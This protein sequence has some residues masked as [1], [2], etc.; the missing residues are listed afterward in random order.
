MN[1][2]DL[3]YLI[4]VAE[5]GHFGRA[6][7]ACFVSQPTLSMQLKKLEERLGVVLFER[8]N[9]QVLITEIGRQL[10]EKARKIVLEV[11]ELKQLAKAYT[12][13]YA[14]SLKLGVIPTVAPYLLPQVMPFIKAKFNQLTLY[15]VEEKTPVLI[16]QLSRGKIDVAIM[17]LP[18]EDEFN[19]QILY[20]E[21]FYF[22]C[23]ST[24]ALAKNTTIALNELTQHPIML[25][26]EGHCLREQ[27]LEI[28]HQ[29][30]VDK[31]ADFSATSLETLR[32]MVAA[33]IGVTMLPALSIIKAPNADIR[34]LSFEDKIPTRQIALFWR[35]NSH[36]QSCFVALS[37]LI[38]DKTQSLLSQ[39]SRHS[40]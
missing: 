8:N 12:S 1:I 13:P 7:K 6:A 16:E 5:F 23:A 29:A 36:R 22:A 9:K 32:L 19:H 26:E 38:S 37:E 4:A 35:K 2:R 24:N 18:I 10:V 15:L 28:C 30:K 21:P 25:L 27:A 34:I 20:N 17:A 39:I 14:G 33:D 40:D 11:D 31:L 3:N